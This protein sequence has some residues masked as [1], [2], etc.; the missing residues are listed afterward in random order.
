[1]DSQLDE[2]KS[3]V[4][5]YPGLKNDVRSGK[6]TWQS[7]YEEWYLYGEDDSQWEKYKEVTQESNQSAPATDKTKS[8]TKSTTTSNSSSATL[9][10]TE[11]MAQAFQYLQKMDMNKVQQ[12]MTTVQKFI[13]LFQTMQG[14]K[15]AGTA[16]GLGAAAS[17]KQSF[18]GLFSKFDD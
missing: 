3:F 4:R 12:T 16:A 13:Q 6:A 1:M 10:G 5:K 2:F 11:M 7:I 14:G 8:E 9:S 18:P 15:G 17:Q